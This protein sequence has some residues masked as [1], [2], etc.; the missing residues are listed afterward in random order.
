MKKTALITGIL[1]ILSLPVLKSQVR[2]KTI[3]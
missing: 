3:K 2:D 1:L